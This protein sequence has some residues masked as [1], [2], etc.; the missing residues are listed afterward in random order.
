MAKKSGK[1]M[2]GDVLY[3]SGMPI[4]YWSKLDQLN[5]RFNSGDWLTQVLLEFDRKNRSVVSGCNC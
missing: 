3:S 1:G 2:R 4:T 5:A